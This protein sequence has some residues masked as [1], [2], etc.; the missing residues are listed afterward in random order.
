MQFIHNTLK[1]AHLAIGLDSIYITSE[2][3]WKM[4]GF[5]FNQVVSSEGSQQLSE[6][7]MDFSFSAP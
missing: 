6:K 1:Q 7:M 2:G 4:A 5:G 3:K